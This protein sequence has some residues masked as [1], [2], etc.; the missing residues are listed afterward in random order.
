MLRIAILFI[1]SPTFEPDPKKQG[2]KKD[3]EKYI[4]YYNNHCIRLHI[5]RMSPIE[6]RAHYNNKSKS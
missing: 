3:K 1:S 2:I 4:E 6:Y 5:K